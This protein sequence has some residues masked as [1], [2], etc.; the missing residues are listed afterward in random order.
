MR[1]YQ[2]IALTA[3]LICLMSLAYHFIRLVRLGAPQDYSRPIGDRK[4]AIAYSLVGAMDPRK[5]ESAYLH[6]P[7]YTA[8]LLYHIGTFIAFVVFGLLLFDVHLTYALRLILMGAFAVSGISGIGILV[9]RAVAKNLKILSSP[10]DYLSNFQVTMVHVL[11]LGMFVND[12]IAP[13]YYL[14]W[15]LL[16]IYLPLGKLKHALYFF[17][18]RYHLGIFYGRRGVWPEIKS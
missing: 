6:L 16:L 17:A 10:D 13:V 11:T 14:W 7:T 9:K 3:F 1:W 2:H 18:A 12:V 8:G 15:G 5:K 4:G